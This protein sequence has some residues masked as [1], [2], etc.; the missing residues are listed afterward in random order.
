MAKLNIQKN[1]DSLPPWAKGVV[2]VI[3]I[4]GIA[5][6]GY[7]LYTKIRDRARLQEAMKVGDFA[8]KELLE[9]AKKGIKPTL[10]KTQLES[11]SLKLQEAMN[12]CGTTTSQIY[13]VF[14]GLKN[15]ADVLALI[16]VFSL[17]YYRPCAVSSPISYAIWLRNERAYGGNLPVWLSYDL[18]SSEIEKIN[19][20]L[21][22]KGIE[23]KF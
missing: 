12:G 22:D 20:I 19:T 18:S 2:G 11:D 15:K 1:Y 17:R 5:A 7:T 9:L 14:E 21:S 6:I 3:V 8:E 4:G 16:S 13:Q 23:Y 10:T